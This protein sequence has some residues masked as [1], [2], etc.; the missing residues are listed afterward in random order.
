MRTK[1]SGRGNRVKGGVG[2]G[3]GEGIR[4]GHDEVGD[5]ARARGRR[6]SGIRSLGG[7]GGPG[8][9]GDARR[10]LVGMI[11]G[12]IGDGAISAL[13]AVRKPI[14]SAEDECGV[15][16]GLEKRSTGDT[17]GDGVC[18]AYTGMDEGVVTR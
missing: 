10:S 7:V 11:R 12:R 1:R 14:R 4:V 18:P 13:K 2:R 6:G 5:I 8:A 9:D 16:G 17:E 15:S 3:V